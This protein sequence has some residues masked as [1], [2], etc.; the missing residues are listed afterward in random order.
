M[1]LSGYGDPVT[2]EHYEVELAPAIFQVRIAF[3]YQASVMHLQ[4]GLH[5]EEE[6][7]EHI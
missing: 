5:G 2:Q 3:S 4:P 7:N 1:N 6:R